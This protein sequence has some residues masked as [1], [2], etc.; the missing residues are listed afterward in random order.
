MIKKIWHWVR[1]YSHL[2]HKHSLAFIY[3]KPPRHY[4][5]HIVEHK[6]PVI[7][8]PG[9]YEKWHFLQTL[10]DPVSHTGHPI[11]VLEHLGYNTEEVHRSAK[12]VR[13]LI[14]EKNLRNVIILAHSK[15]GL[16]GKHLL[17]FDNKDG[18]IK[19]VVAI[20]TPFAGSRFPRVTR[21]K[22]LREFHPEHETLK[23]LKKQSHINHRV[24]SIFGE[25][26]NH[27]WPT[28]SCRLEGA[29]NIQVHS[30]G[31]HAILFSKKVRDIVMT[32]VEEIL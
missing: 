28:E 8:I 26:D 15:G 29:K 2:L 7:L 10:A 17:A 9:V 16:I 11:Y 22:N 21:W 27:V 32:E 12:L 18:R 30:H 20:A 6:A 23:K 4:L 19:K 25:Y 13:E 31:H 5:G 14:D 1:D 3:R 24:V